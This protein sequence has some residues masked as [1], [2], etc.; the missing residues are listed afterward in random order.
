MSIGGTLSPTR[1]IGAARE[2]PGHRSSGGRDRGSEE[3]DAPVMSITTATSKPRVA[4]IDQL[5]TEWRS[6]GRSR[7][8]V[9]SLRD[10]AGRDPGLSLLVLGPATGQ[11]PC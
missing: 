1:S 11:P 8:A 3:A 5:A 7:A 4:L 6:I 10:I 9:R 2:A